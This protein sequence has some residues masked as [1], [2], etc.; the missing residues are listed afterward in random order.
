MTDHS[1]TNDVC[2]ICLDD[3]TNNVYVTTCNHGFHEACINQWLGQNRTCPLCRTRIPP[4]INPM[5]PLRPT[6]PQI[7]LDSLSVQTRYTRIMPISLLLH[8]QGLFIGMP[9]NG[10]TNRLRLRPD[11]AI[12]YPVEIQYLR[13]HAN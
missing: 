6:E 10:L 11:L 7:M 9:I 1:N 13:I 5:I 12:R 3:I 8:R 4:V 2:P